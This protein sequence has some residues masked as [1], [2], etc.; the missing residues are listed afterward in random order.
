MNTKPSTKDLLKQR[1]L[2]YESADGEVYGEV[3]YQEL[4]DFLSAV[5][6]FRTPEQFK[7]FSAEHPFIYLFPIELLNEHIKIPKHRFD[8]EGEHIKIYR[9]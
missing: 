2:Y 8:K 6:Y 9:I 5:H 4:K 7:P 1:T 3:S